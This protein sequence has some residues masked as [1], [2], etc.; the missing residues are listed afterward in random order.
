MECGWETFMAQKV[1][2]ALDCRHV[3]IAKQTAAD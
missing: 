1:H 2:E 3:Q